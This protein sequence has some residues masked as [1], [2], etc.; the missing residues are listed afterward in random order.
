M[1]PQRSRKRI[2]KGNRHPPL[3]RNPVVNC[4]KRFPYCC[5]L[6]V[7]RCLLL[8]CA[9]LFTC[10]THT[11]SN[12][13][14]ARFALLLKSLPFSALRQQPPPRVLAPRAFS[15]QSS[16]LRKYSVDRRWV[17]AAALSVARCSLSAAPCPVVR[18]S[19]ACSNRAAARF[20]LLLN[21][22]LL[23][24][25]RQQPPPH[26]PQ[27]APPPTPHPPS[28]DDAAMVKFP[29]QPNRPRLH[30]MTASILAALSGT[31]GGGV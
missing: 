24:A 25:L 17:F 15:R 29:A 14:A 13:A 31:P 23:P 30:K 22:Q 3:P 4:D 11:C 16:V 19:H 1:P 6:L 27:V 28:I 7:A 26:P 12:R 21:S 9:L 2:L 8:A 18:C 20:A 5:S 10:S